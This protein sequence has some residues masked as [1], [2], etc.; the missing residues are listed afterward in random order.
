MR[1]RFAIT[2]SFLFV[3]A[4][5]LAQQPAQD[6]AAVRAVAAGFGKALAAGDSAA[7]LALLHPDVVIFEGG[8]WESLE[9]YRRGHLSADMRALQGR[10]QETVRDQVTINGELALITREYRTTSADGVR[11]GAETMVLLRT[12]NGWKIRHI[13]WSSRARRAPEG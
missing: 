5:V 12:S 2:A 11:T 13:H 1:N 9:D 6:E 7:A 4:P 8:A 3:A 10:T